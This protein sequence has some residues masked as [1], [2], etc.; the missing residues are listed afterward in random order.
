MLILV[1][2]T[3]KG[4]SSSW[5]KIWKMVGIF[6]CMGRKG[7]REVI[8]DWAYIQG[9][10]YWANYHVSWRD[11]VW[12]GRF[13]FFLFQKLHVNF[14]LVFHSQVIGVLQCSIRNS[15]SPIVLLKLCVCILEQFLRCLIDRPFGVAGEPGK[16][17]RDRYRAAHLVIKN[18]VSL[19]LPSGISIYFSLSHWGK[20]QWPV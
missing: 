4:C 12:M 15:W 8:S 3:W 20:N 10:G 17:I 13:A 19:N 18:K 11:G 2:D 16:L 5:Q 14:I 1:Q 6:R 9:T 7:S